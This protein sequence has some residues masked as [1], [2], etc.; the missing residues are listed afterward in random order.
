[1]GLDYYDFKTYMMKINEKM[2]EKAGEIKEKAAEMKQYADEIKDYYD[3]PEKLKQKA[4]EVA[5][6]KSKEYFK[7][8]LQKGVQMTKETYENIDTSLYTNPIYLKNMYKF[9]LS[10]KLI[11]LPTKQQAQQAL[12][13]LNVLSFIGFPVSLPSWVGFAGYASV[14]HDYYNKNKKAKEEKN[15][16]YK[17]LL[18]QLK[19]ESKHYKNIT[20]EIIDCF[21]NE[22]KLNDITEIINKIEDNFFRNGKDEFLKHFNGND[23]DKVYNRLIYHQYVPNDEHS[24]NILLKYIEYQSIISNGFLTLVQ[25]I[26]YQ[27]DLDKELYTTVLFEPT[28]SIMSLIKSS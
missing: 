28:P 26:I 27:L 9:G 14:I 11:Q 18:K 3:N 25:K 17:T 7:E 8:S 20:I 2:I 16:D 4:T 13:G 23:E 24:L 19:D 22:L 5:I 15:V 21:R 12:T 10:L 1:M 6:E